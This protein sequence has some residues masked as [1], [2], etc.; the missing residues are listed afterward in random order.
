MR[1]GIIALAAASAHAAVLKRSDDGTSMVSVSKAVYESEGNGT[2]SYLYLA[3][4]SYDIVHVSGTNSSDDHLPSSPNHSDVI[5]DLVD[6]ATVLNSTGLIISG[7]SEN[8]NNQ[9]V[10][11]ACGS[12]SCEAA[13][14]SITPNTILSLP[15]SCGGGYF[16]ITDLV[17]EL[18]NCDPAYA[19]LN[20]TMVKEVTFHYNWSAANVALERRDIQPIAML[21]EMSSTANESDHVEDVQAAAS[22]LTKRSC[23]TSCKWYDIVCWAEKVN[24]V[25]VGYDSGN[26]KFNYSFD[27]LLVGGEATCNSGNEVNLDI[28]SAGNVHYGGDAGARI[29]GTIIPPAVTA[30]YAYVNTSGAVNFD[31][32]VD[33]NVTLTYDTGILTLF[34]APVFSYTV[35]GILELGLTAGVAAEVKAELDFAGHFETYIYFNLPTVDFAIGKN[36]PNTTSNQK[37]ANSVGLDKHPVATLNALAAN[38]AGV[39]AKIGG[40]LALGL[41]VLSGLID[42]EAGVEAGALAGVNLNVTADGD[43]GTTISAED[44]V[45]LGLQVYVGG[46]IDLYA[47]YAT[48][49][50]GVSGFADYPLLELK[51]LLLDEK[52]LIHNATVN[53]S[54]GFLE[55]VT[56][57]PTII[58][59]WNSTVP[60]STP[61]PENMTA[62]FNSTA[63]ESAIDKLLG[64]SHSTVVDEVVSELGSVL[65]GNTT[66]TSTSIGTIVAQLLGINSNTTVSVINDVISE[67][68]GLLTGNSTSSTIA[69]IITDILKVVP[70]VSN[71]KSV[72]SIVAIFADALSGN[73]TIV[74][75]DIGNAVTSLLGLKT[76]SNVAGIDSIISNVVSLL[77][78]SGTSSTLGTIISNVLS[79]ASVSSSSST[80]VLNTVVS[81]LAGILSGNSSVESSVIDSVISKVVSVGNNS[82]SSLVDTI[83]ADLTSLLSSSSSSE[84][85]ME[86]VLSQVLSAYTGA[87]TTSFANIIADL[88][89]FSN[90]GNTSL[91]QVV[92]GELT[93]LESGNSGIS[94]A[95][96][97]LESL[98]EGASTSTNT[99]VSAKV[100][101]RSSDTPLLNLDLFDL[102]CK[103]I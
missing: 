60:G 55:K 6:D 2:T 12:S 1:W 27:Q 43:V 26:V 57:L 82:T 66:L 51:Y 85:F 41:R 59:E 13:Y 3:G 76:S 71:S 100:S 102:V 74:S 11:I 38:T 16:A 54:I 34:S 56:T 79:L 23:P 47:Q 17:T 101:R 68:T 49:I 58:S 70:E 22:S 61:T 77:S 31:L 65:V 94:S 78:G 89:T 14:D 97:K 40:K 42:A 19:E 90:T 48:P 36:A 88:V 72:N 81:D 62:T 103:Y 9:T 92:V 7:C 28:R 8:A 83:V 64:I 29:I 20:A 99:L 37:S 33:A 84:N 98:I 32:T 35:P 44:N 21:Y 91:A 10:L 87:N 96:S 39:E 25:N 4:S 50:P 93:K 73:Y 69:G 86:T 75:T 46:N 45:Y 18:P 80:S 15:A 63:I 24:C 53:N 95:L 30:A 5:G 52:L 67:L